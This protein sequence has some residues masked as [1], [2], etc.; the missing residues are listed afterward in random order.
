MEIRRASTCHPERAVAFTANEGPQS[1]KP[2][3]ATPPP[4]PQLGF[5]RACKLVSQSHPS[6]IPAITGSPESP[7]LAFWGGITC[8]VGDLSK[9]RAA[10]I[11]RASNCHPE[12]AVAF[13]ANEGPQSAKPLPAPLFCISV[14]NKGPSANLP[15]GDP[16]VTLGWPL[17]G[18]SAQGPPNPRPNP[19]VIPSG[20]GF[21]P[22][23]S[24]FPITRS[25]DHQTPS[26]GAI[27]A[28]PQPVIVSDRCNRESNDLDWR[29]PLYPL[30]PGGHPRL[31]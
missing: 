31:A 15:M 1:A 12:R 7:V 17:G 24:A 6:P 22:S 2:T 14:E 27:I 9:R 23:A 5:Q 10:Q 25:P 29:S 20:V 30:P 28:A 16:C 8:D 26:R 11:R 13:A 4:I 19:K 21:T 18:P 3:N